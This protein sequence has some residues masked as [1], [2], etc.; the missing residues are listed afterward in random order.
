M[1]YQKLFPNRSFQFQILH[2]WTKM[3]P[4]KIKFSDSLKFN[5]G[6]IAYPTP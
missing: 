5:E 4:T 3:F 2:F 1:N 6:A